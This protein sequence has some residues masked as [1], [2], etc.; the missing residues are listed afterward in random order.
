M[1]VGQGLS[2]INNSILSALLSIPPNKKISSLCLP[3]CLIQSGTPTKCSVT[4][5]LEYKTSRIQNITKH[6]GYITSGIQTS[7]IKNIHDQNTQD[8][9]RPG[10]IG[11]NTVHTGY[12][13]QGYKT[14]SLQNVHNTKRPVTNLPID[15]SQDVVE[16]HIV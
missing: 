13:V 12:K 6:P 14:S 11:Y 2:A 1:G 16:D 5:R 7:G 8:T 15:G 10:C 9:K 3:S 4:E